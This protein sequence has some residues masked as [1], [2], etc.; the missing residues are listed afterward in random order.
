MR[1][2]TSFAGTFNGYYCFRG[3]AGTAVITKVQKEVPKIS[4]GAW[5]GFANFVIFGMF[6][7]LMLGRILLDWDFIP[8]YRAVKLVMLGY[9]ALIAGISRAI[10]L[11][12]KNQ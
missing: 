9:E 11:V 5:Y 2:F 3:P 7:G 6:F 1:N 12:L 4:G 10:Y 8:T